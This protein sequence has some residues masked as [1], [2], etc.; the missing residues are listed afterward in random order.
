MKY[1]HYFSYKFYIVILCIL[2]VLIT[3]RKDEEVILEFTV[4]TR[5]ATNIGQG[6]ATL[7]GSVNADNKVCKI[8]FE[9]D[10]S[11]AYTYSISGIPDTVSS[12]T[13]ETIWANLSGL[14]PETEYY[15]RLKTEYAGGTEYG[16]DMTFITTG[17]SSIDIDFNPDL[18]YGTVTDI[19]GNIYK[20]IIIGSQ[21]WMAENLKVTRLNDG[22][23]IPF[24]PVTTTW[25]ALS[26]SGYCWYNNDSIAYGAL[27]NCYTVDSNDL[28]P[29]GWHVP[30]SEEWSVMI[31]FLG[32]ENIAGGKLKETGTTHWSVPNFGATNES[33]FTALAG[34]YRSSAG[35]Y[36]SIQQK[37]FLWSSTEHTSDH[38]YY[39]IMSYSYSNI[40]MNNSNKKNA[41]S[42]RCVK[43]N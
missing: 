21:T 32:G 34:G 35:V 33:G 28:C 13:T 19:D 20:T 1:Q 40:D 9:Y 29:Q 43:D 18:V 12:D 31:N 38:A 7:N 25:S 3:C 4:T 17:L 36:K 11:T 26:T 8:S 22:T 27:Y 2:L 6:W 24:V 14:S 16:D 5:S 39:Y 30:D 41:F 37:G 10:T 15:F 42:V 23:L